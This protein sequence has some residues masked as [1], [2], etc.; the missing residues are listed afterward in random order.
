LTAPRARAAV[1]DERWSRCAAPVMLGAGWWVCPGVQGARAVRLRSAWPAR[2]ER[3][4]V[5]VRGRSD[6]DPW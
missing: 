6:A 3:Q 5:R 4:R 2:L 1:R